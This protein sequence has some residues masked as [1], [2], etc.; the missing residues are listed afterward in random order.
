M[1][2]I[3]FCVE[4]R[5][6]RNMCK[7][8]TEGIL[9]HIPKSGNELELMLTDMDVSDMTTFIIYI[10]HHAG[11]EKFKHFK[12]CCVDSAKKL[13]ENI[14]AVSEQTKPLT[15][16]DNIIEMVKS[17][18][19]FDYASLYSDDKSKAYMYS[20]KVIYQSERINTCN[21]EIPIVNVFEYITYISDTL[22]ICS[23]HDSVENMFV[24]K[25]FK[26]AL[27]TIRNI[28]RDE[29]ET[30]K[31]AIA[32]LQD[33][34]NKEICTLDTILDVILLDKIVHMIIFN[35]RITEII[36]K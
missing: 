21:Y 26:R 30:F 9:A 6:K 18:G 3:V 25:N 23:I 4:D 36:T 29:V 27:C 15:C 12:Q 24:K 13:I 7:G 1:R 22:L 33:M 14:T 20:P 32:S 31:T 5:E 28:S 16:S 10:R 17:T 35:D 19:M 8:Y 11:D 34:I 2:S